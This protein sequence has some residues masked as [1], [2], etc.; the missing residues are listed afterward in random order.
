MHRIHRVLTKI[1][2]KH[3]SSAPQSTAT[4]CIDEEY[5]DED[6]E[7]ETILDASAKTLVPKKVR[8]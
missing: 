2:D 6:K 4:E 5:S 7:A 8:P 3:D 1:S